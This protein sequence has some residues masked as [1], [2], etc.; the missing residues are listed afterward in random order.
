MPAMLY[1]LWIQFCLILNFINV[2]TAG[3]FFILASFIQ[4]YIC[5]VHLLQ[6][7]N[8]LLLYSI[9]W[10]YHIL[11]LILSSLGIWI[12][13]SFYVKFLH[14]WKHGTY[15]DILYAKVGHLQPL[16]TVWIPERLDSI[17]CLELVLEHV[18]RKAFH[19]CLICL[20]WVWQ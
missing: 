14:F 19:Y 13:P 12:V 16:F 7:I 11:C 5:E 18:Q 9:V 4:H 15:Q 6:F 10:V 8:F 20:W 2:M 3:I 1:L 17:L